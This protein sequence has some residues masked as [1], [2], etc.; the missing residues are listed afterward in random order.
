MELD[1]LAEYLRD[2]DTLMEDSSSL[3]SNS[4]RRRLTHEAEST[5]DVFQDGDSNSPSIKVA[6]HSSQVGAVVSKIEDIFESIADCILD[7]KKELV[8]QL[9]C[10]HRA[11]TN[12]EEGALDRR[13]K[14]SSGGRKITFPSKNEKEA[15]KFSKLMSLLDCMCL[16]WFSS[17]TS[18]T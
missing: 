4:P 16:C 5:E 18:H 15:W 2:D 10:R 17:V 3:L 13:R 12:D 7:E 14:A 11:K 9:K 6:T 8:I 1:L